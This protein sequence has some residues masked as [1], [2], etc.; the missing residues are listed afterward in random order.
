MCANQPSPAISLPSPNVVFGLKVATETFYA[1]ADED[2][3][4]DQQPGQLVINEFDH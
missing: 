4:E 3:E 1:S 2:E